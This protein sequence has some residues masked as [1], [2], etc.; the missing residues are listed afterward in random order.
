MKIFKFKLLVSAIFCTL[1][2]KPLIGS[3][4]INSPQDSLALVDLYNSTN[5]P[6]WVNDSNW[7]TK[8][9]LGSW[10]GVTV[11]NQRV[12]RLLLPNN[13]LIGNLPVTLGNLSA[14]SV[15]AVNINQLSGNIPSSLNNLINLGFLDLSNNQYSGSFPP[16]MFSNL[17]ALIVVSIH[18]NQFTFTGVESLHGNNIISLYYPQADIPIASNGNILS[19]SAGG[20]LSE[21]TYNWYKDDSLVLSR[22][23]NSS[24]SVATPGNY[25]VKVS[26]SSVYSQ[27]LILYSITKPNQT[28]SLA[29]VDLYKGTSGFGWVNHTNWLTTAPLSSWYGVTLRQGRVILLELPGNNLLGNLPSS[30]STLSNLT[31]LD[32]NSN[33][34]ND[35]IPSSFGYMPNLSTLELS[36]NNLNGLLPSSLSGLPHL[37][38]L[39][40]NNNQF[41][42]TIPLSWGSFSTLQWLDLSNNL[43]SGAIPDTLGKVSSLAILSLS[44]N[45]LSGNIPLA[46]CNLNLKQLVL[47]RNQLNGSIPDSIIKLSNLSRL[48]LDNNQLSGSIPDSLGNLNKIFDLD[49]SNNF[50]SGSVPSFTKLSLSAF[51]ID[52]NKFTFAGL[53]TLPI[54]YDRTYSPQATVPSMKNG[55]HLSVSVGGTLSNNTFRLFKDGMLNATQT[56]DSSFLVTSDGEYYISITN[57]IASQLTLY[58]NPVTL[59]TSFNSIADGNWNDPSVWAGGTVPS[60]TS[61]VTVNNSITVTANAICYSLK[62]LPPTGN[63]VVLTGV[64][65]TVTH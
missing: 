14:I 49:L 65:L 28:D 25:S 13:K 55:T 54:V 41:I 52:N 33:L 53:E 3:T 18:H 35:S 62:I 8:A 59:A 19:V 26:S 27:Q 29:L 6:G 42:G 10:Y 7:L 2:F 45:H 37:E 61:I 21:N 51:H 34:L 24:F 15:L 60:S 47:S 4:Q 44:N 50:L 17:P 32:L 16:N 22:K 48:W 36:R 43:I 5:G 57:S 40:L 46:L 31:L 56:G 20:N 39:F 63:L 64:N 1:F 38:S 12:I 58:S 23:G 11:E 9:P 30:I